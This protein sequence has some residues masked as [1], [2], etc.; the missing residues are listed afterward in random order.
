MSAIE[1]VTPSQAAGHAAHQGGTPPT[2]SFPYGFPSPGAYRLFVP[3]KRG[4]AMVTSAFD[5]DVK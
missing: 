4:G 5:A 3:V 1:I 2:V